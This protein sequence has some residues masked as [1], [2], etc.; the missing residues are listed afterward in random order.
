MADSYGSG[1]NSMVSKGSHLLVVPENATQF[2]NP[3]LT[4][5]LRYSQ[6]S[7]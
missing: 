3:V 2:Y 4:C 5:Y 1:G 6:S 7:S